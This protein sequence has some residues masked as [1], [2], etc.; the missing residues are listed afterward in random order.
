MENTLHSYDP[1]NGES[2][3]SV[4]VSDTEA[5]QN[6]VKRA[7][8]AQQIWANNPLQERVRLLQKAYTA[9]EAQE[10]KLAQLISREMGKDSRR[11]QY[12]AGGVVRGGAWLAGDAGEALRTKRNSGSEIQYRPLG[13]VAVISPWNYPLAMA[14][15]LIVPALIAGN[16][17]IL[18]PSEESPLVADLLVKTLTQSLPEGVLQIAH[19]DG[20]TGEALVKSS[21]NM[22]AFTGSRTTGQKIMANAAPAL[23]RLVMELGGNDPM[24]VLDSANIPQAVQFAV[25]SSF[26]NSG[27]MCTSTERIYVDEKIADQFEN[28]VVALAKQY[29][30]GG[31]Q[32]PQVDI[33]PLVNQRQHQKVV[34][35][36]HDALDKGAKLL[37]GDRNPQVP[38][39]PPTVI[40][41]I[42]PGMSMEDDE[43]FG[44]IVAIDRFSSVD[45]VVERANNSVYGLGAVVFGE[46]KEA[47]QVASHLQAG[48]IGINQGA[49][50]SPWVGAKQSG[51]GFHGGAEGHRQFAQITVLNR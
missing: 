31:W 25:G 26:E 20:K 19:G 27:Q 23:K 14:N 2:I 50:G 22:V 46:S 12:E 17:V 33:G 21:I 34:E 6:L 40:S 7:A 35:H 42:R 48:M 39:I 51:F 44:P 45:D 47:E 36:I 9:L 4:P 10:E 11:A 3:G 18:K 13:I 28:A 16:T 15:N 8:K 49:G 43:T 41:G 30:V 29:R 38:F 5:I 1:L 37:L 32:E 24:I